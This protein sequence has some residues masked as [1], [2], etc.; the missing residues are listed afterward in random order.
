MAGRLSHH[1]CRLAAAAALVI[2]SGGIAVAA[3]APASAVA[4]GGPGCSISEGY[5]LLTGPPRISAHYS[6]TCEDRTAPGPIDIARLVN[7]SWQSV[8]TGNGALIYTC[9]GSTEYEY[10]VVVAVNYEFEDACG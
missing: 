3:A 2:T 9:Q 8:A 7:G 6:I 1:A 4:N 5:T 10:E